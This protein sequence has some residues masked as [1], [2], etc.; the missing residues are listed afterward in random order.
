[1]WDLETLTFKLG[2]YH[3]IL[4][5]R[6]AKQMSGDLTFICTVMHITYFFLTNKKQPDHVSP[7]QTALFGNW[8]K[9]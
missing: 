4:D 6:Q 8:A 9:Y 5:R 1:M 2:L 7:T 3:T